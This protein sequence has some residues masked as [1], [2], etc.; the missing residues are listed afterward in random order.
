MLKAAF[1]GVH[2]GKMSL[3]LMSSLMSGRGDVCTAPLASHQLASPSIRLTCLS[4]Y[5]VAWSCLAG[6][7]SSYQ[8]WKVQ[9]A[10]SNS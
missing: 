2:G 1:P 3:A 6:A 7:A 9:L 8:R 5:L 10:A 4:I